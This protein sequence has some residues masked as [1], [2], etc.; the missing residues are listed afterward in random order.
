MYKKHLLETEILLMVHI[1]F[2]GLR[3]TLARVFITVKKELAN[4]IIL[5]NRSNLVDNHYALILDIKK[6]DNK[7]KKSVRHT[8]VVNIYDN[9]VG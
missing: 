6:R 1:V 2:G 7:Y 8:R 4:R 3:R 5:E 9:W